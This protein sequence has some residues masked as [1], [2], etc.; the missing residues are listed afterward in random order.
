MGDRGWPSWMQG[1]RLQELPVSD[2]FILESD[3]RFSQEACVLPPCGI[4]TAGVGAAG[5]KNDTVSGAQSCLSLS[6]PATESPGQNSVWSRL[7]GQCGATR[8]G[9]CE[10]R[11]ARLRKRPWAPGRGAGPV[12]QDGGWH[13]WPRGGASSAQEAGSARQ[14]P[15]PVAPPRWGGLCVPQERRSPAQKTLTAG[16]VR[17]KDAASEEAI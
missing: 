1:V 9:C 14:S 4:L 7:A 16:G 8:P 17:P 13:P 15:R 11:P 12:S 2:L 3:L 10:A 6:N 5:K